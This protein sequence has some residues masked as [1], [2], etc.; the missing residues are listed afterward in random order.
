MADDPL[1]SIYQL[2]LRQQKISEDTARLVDSMV[3]D[4]GRSRDHGERL[5][6]ILNR[7]DNLEHMAGDW[8]RKRTECSASIYQ[9]LQQLEVKREANKDRMLALEAS[10]ARDINECREKTRAILDQAINPVETCLTELREKVATSAGKYGA[11]VALITSVLLM[12]LQWV[13]SHPHTPPK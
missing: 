5:A 7:L 6:I 12:L 10:V 9:Q 13:I 2:L 3:S 11:I 4:V 8:E 1:Q